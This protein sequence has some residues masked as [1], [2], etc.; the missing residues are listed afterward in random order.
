MRC[1]QISLALP[2]SYCFTEPT[3]TKSSSTRSLGIKVIALYLTVLGML[4][5]LVAGYADDISIP[6]TGWVAPLTLSGI[7]CVI[8]IALLRLQEWSRIAAISLCSCYVVYLAFGLTPVFSPTSVGLGLMLAVIDP[9]RSFMVAMY[10]HMHMFG[11]FVLFI[12]SYLFFVWAA[13]RHLR[14]DYHP[15]GYHKQRDDQIPHQAQGGVPEGQAMTPGRRGAD[16]A[17]LHSV[18]ILC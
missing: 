13:L 17:S 2:P 11:Q 4:G 16:M 14:S 7:L 3:M 15:I 8:G 12:F 10:M 5:L 1:G 6:S 9:S 18:L